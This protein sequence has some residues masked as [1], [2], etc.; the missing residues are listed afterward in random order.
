M[1]NFLYG[2]VVSL[3]LIFLYNIK[4]DWDSYELAK[5]YY[6]RMQQ[7]ATKAIK[8]EGQL[9]PSKIAVDIEPDTPW[10][11]IYKAIFAVLSTALGLALIKKYVK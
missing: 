7:D 3:S 8:I 11:L 9:G 10:E 2:L 6:V 4:Q 1:K 5:D